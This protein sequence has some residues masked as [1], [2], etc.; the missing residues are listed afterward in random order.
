MR[1]NSQGLFGPFSRKSW[2][3]HPKALEPEVL[4]RLWAASNGPLSEREVQGMPPTPPVNLS[5]LGPTVTN[6]LQVLLLHTSLPIH[7]C[8]GV[9]K[10]GH[11]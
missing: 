7:Y 5:P 9:R 10:N 8:T 3:S 2:L 11:V 1:S 4:S 6:R